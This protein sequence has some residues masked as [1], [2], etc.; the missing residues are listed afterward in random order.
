MNIYAQ[1][2]G[3]L[4]MLFLINSYFNTKKKNYLFSQIICNIFFAIQ[5][6]ILNAM[7]AVINAFIAIIRSFVFYFYTK[8]NKKI[9]I[10]VLIIF[11]ICIILLIIITCRS[12]IALLPL[13]IAVI[14]TYGTWQ[15]NL[16][17][18]YFI[19][20]IVATIWIIY[21]FYVGAYVAGIGSIFEL[22]SSINGIY[23]VSKKK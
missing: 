13:L 14:Y 5:Y 18:T 9:P 21:N 10:K 7:T 20:S 4:A 2:F 19:G 6:F 1:I 8:K 16:K 22:I 23:R 15:K 17:V 11:E 12:F 3:I